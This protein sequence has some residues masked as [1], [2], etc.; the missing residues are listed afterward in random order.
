MERVQAQPAATMPGRRKSVFYEIGLV[1]ETTIREERTRAPILKSNPILKRH[2]PT[3][4]VRFRSQHDVFQHTE[5]VKE[6]DSD[7]EQIWNLNIEVP[8]TMKLNSSQYL[9]TYSKF[10]RLA[11]L[12]VMLA[13]LLPI[14]STN[15]ISAIGVKGGVIPSH[16][17]TYVAATA[18]P[19]REDTNTNICKRWSHQC[20]FQLRSYCSS[21]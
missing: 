17:D 20:K 6:D 15:P 1:D 8:T 14:L 3:R 5:I 7:W 4:L 12:A 21:D 9:F 11:G 13:L 16:P 18:F 19:K 10:Y 2:R